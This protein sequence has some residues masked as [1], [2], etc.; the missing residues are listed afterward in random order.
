LTASERRAQI[1][2][3]KRFHHGGVSPD[4]RV[5]FSVDATGFG[6]FA[7]VAPGADWAVIARDFGDEETVLGLE[8]LAALHKDQLSHP[9]F[10]APAGHA[11][12]CPARK[13][14][15]T[16]IFPTTFSVTILNS[17]SPFRVTRTRSQSQKQSLNPVR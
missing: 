16:F 7:A 10:E 9:A 1:G 17:I 5:D 4:E 2:H 14:D 13:M 12:E 8:R 6:G 3:S 11:S 15:L